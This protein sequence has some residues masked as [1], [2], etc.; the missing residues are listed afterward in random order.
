MYASTRGSRVPI[1]AGLRG[2]GA[3][4]LREEFGSYD[5]DCAATIS[6][7]DFAAE[8]VRRKNIIARV[9]V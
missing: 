4:K 6:R 5:L 9:R 3:A 8:F 7:L 1:G 2:C